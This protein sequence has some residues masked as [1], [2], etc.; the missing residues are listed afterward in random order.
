VIVTLIQKHVCS[1]KNASGEGN[2]MITHGDFEVF[3]LAQ[4]PTTVCLF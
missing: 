3:S 1:S 4:D 2:I